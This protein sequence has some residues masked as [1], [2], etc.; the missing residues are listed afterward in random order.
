MKRIKFFEAETRMELETDVN[1]WLEKRR[2]CDLV[3]FRL[4]TGLAEEP[5]RIGLLIYEQPRADD[6][7][8]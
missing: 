7:I 1:R 8:L 4:I 3:D 5:N 6:G 2:D